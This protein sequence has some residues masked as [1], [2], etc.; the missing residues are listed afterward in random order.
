MQ[1]LLIMLNVDH[2]K[3]DRI[4]NA[5]IAYVCSRATPSVP[6]YKVYSLLR[7]FSKYMVY[8][9]ASLMFTIF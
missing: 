7:K 5:E 4:C 1:T 9:V 8:C 3:L 6:R 2:H